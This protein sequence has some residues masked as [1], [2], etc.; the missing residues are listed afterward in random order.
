M[1]ICTFSMEKILLYILHVEVFLFCFVL[2]IGDMCTICEPSYQCQKGCIK[3][4][5][6]FIKYFVS[7]LD[8]NCTSKKLYMWPAPTKPG[9]SRMGLFWDIGH[10]NFQCKNIVR[11]SHF[12][13][14]CFCNPWK[15]YLQQKHFGADLLLFCASNDAFSGFVCID[16]NVKCKL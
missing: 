2:L 9:T 11:R 6:S 3:T 15:L 7:I 10:W 16:V 14:W 13:F 8:R 4:N 1:L 12:R 5:D